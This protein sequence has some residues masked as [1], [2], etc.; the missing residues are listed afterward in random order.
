[1]LAGDPSKRNFTGGLDAKAISFACLGGNQPETNNIPNYNCPGGLRAQVFFPACWDGK[2]L[3]SPDHKSH[4]VSDLDD[5]Q[6]N[7]MF[8]TPTAELS[9]WPEF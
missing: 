3:D 6:Y 2:N 8:L 5:R 9:Q 7:S 1:M 4:M